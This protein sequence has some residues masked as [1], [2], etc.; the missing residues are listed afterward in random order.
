MDFIISSEY[1][2]MSM[3]VSFLNNFNKKSLLVKVD[4]NMKGIEKAIINIIIYLIKSN[5]F[6]LFL[7]KNDLCKINWIKEK[8]VVK[9]Y[10]ENIDINTIFKLI[11][12]L[13]M[14]TEYVHK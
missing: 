2:L 13:D 8:M 14:L 6:K 11:V 4:I 9:K 3:N 7:F 12:K 5:N 1:V 10:K